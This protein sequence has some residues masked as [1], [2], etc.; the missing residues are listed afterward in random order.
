M[1]HGHEQDWTLKEIKMFV[2]QYLTGGILLLV[3]HC[4]IIHPDRRL[5]AS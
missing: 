1:G 5:M 2:S 4:P 3:V